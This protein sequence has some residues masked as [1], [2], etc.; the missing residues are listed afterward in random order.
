VDSS[1]PSKENEL[2]KLYFF[3]SA[4]ISLLPSSPKKSELLFEPQLPKM[5]KKIHPFSRFAKETTIH[6]NGSTFFRDVGR[7]QF[8]TLAFGLRL[9]TASPVGPSD[10]LACPP[11]DGIS[12]V[13]L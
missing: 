8:A 5:K 12:P 2:N 13:S 10:A 1:L 7:A 4:P 6:T 11:K 9:N 3:R